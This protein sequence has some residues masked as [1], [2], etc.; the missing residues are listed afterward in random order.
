MLSQCG[1]LSTNSNVS[2]LNIQKLCH[3]DVIVMELT[4]GIQN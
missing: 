1:K 3:G 2:K 4:T